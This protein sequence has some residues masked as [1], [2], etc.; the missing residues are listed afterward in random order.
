M[1][2]EAKRRVDPSVTSPEASF[3]IGEKGQCGVDELYSARPRAVSGPTSRVLLK[4]LSGAPEER[5]K[6]VSQLRLPVTDRPPHPQLVSVLDAVVQDGAVWA[7]LE[8]VDGVSLGHLL[9]LSARRGCRLPASVVAV[10]MQDVLLGLQEVHIRLLE[11]GSSTVAHGALSLD[12]VFVCRDGQSK[13]LNLGLGG[14][15]ERTGTT[16]W[17]RFSEGLHLSPPELLKGEPL[18]PPSD[19]YSVCVALWE[20]LSQRSLFKKESVHETMQAVLEE[21]LP[22]DLGSLSALDLRFLIPGLDR[23]VGR[24]FQSPDEL[25]AV[26]RQQLP[27][28]T[29]ADVARWLGSLAPSNA[30]GSG[31]VSRRP[32]AQAAPAKPALELGAAAPSEEPTERQTPG[33]LRQMLS[34]EPA[35]SKGPPPKPPSRA[36][37]ARVLEPADSGEGSTVREPLGALAKAIPKLSPPPPPNISRVNQLK[38]PVVPGSLP[39]SAPGD[40]RNEPGP[41]ALLSRPDASNDFEFDPLDEDDTTPEPSVWA[42]F[43]ASDL[44]G[45]ATSPVSEAGGRVR[46]SVVRL[47]SLSSHLVVRLVLLIALGV[48]VGVV[49]GMG[50]KAL[51]AEHRQRS[52]Q[53]AQWALEAAQQRHRQRS[54]GSG[55]VQE[56]DQRAAEGSSAVAP[57]PHP[58]GNPRV[59]SIE[60]LPKVRSR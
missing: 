58:R 20:I 53:Q 39:D 33:R 59:F 25:R 44:P 16:E 10:I 4:R 1:P 31:I 46:R 19:T 6:L 50:I 3:L 29:Q 7:V 27:L 45:D 60:D 43:P 32:L 57:A 5:Q 41:S 12:S 55:S 15:P 11:D 13:L 22:A 40:Q 8:Q 34:V 38:A 54:L 23:D 36:A 21:P 47:L 37:A 42:R 17:A 48:S 24:R 56:A 9:E 28:G 30:D 35:G 49:A 26:I 2:S 14:T 52:L 51:I 18:G